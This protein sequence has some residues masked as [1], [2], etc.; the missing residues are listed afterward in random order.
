MKNMIRIGYLATTCLI[1]GALCLVWHWR[2]SRNNANRAMPIQTEAAAN[3]WA[4]DFLQRA[5]VPI[6][7]L[8]IGRITTKPDRLK[9][10]RVWIV[11]IPHTPSLAAGSNQVVLVYERGYFSCYQTLTGGHEIE[12]DGDF[13][14]I[15][16]GQGVVL[17]LIR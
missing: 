12:I 6:T 17:P 16:R 2:T 4:V 10:Q 15:N 9:G 5:G 1:I 14:T 3:H 13:V 7:N 8:D 11:D